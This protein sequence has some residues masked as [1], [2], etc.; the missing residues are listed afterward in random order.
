MA[1]QRGALAE[2]QKCERLRARLVTLA[3]FHAASSRLLRIQYAAIT[4]M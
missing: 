4:A 2:T 3:A 1:L